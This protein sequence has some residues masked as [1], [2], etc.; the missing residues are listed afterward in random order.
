[1]RRKLPRLI[2]TLS[3]LAAPALAQVPPKDQAAIADTIRRQIDAFARDDGPAAFAFATPD[4]QTMFGNPENFMA[5]VRRGYQ[6]V[7]RP[8]AYRFAPP[9]DRNG[10]I[11][12]PMPLIGPD[13]AN[14]VAIYTMERDEAGNWRIAGCR[15]EQRDTP[16]S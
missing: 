6:P 16:S 2:A 13:G 5:M 14:W 12:Q 3:L 15:L 9:E 8:R 10:L 1:M 7:Y 4:L 11:E